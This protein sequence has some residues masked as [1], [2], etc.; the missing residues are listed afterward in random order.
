M[1]GFLGYLIG[2]AGGL[3]VGVIIGAALVS[4]F[5]WIQSGGV[6]IPYDQTHSAIANH[7]KVRD[8]TW[9]RNLAVKH[10][11]TGPVEF[12][13]YAPQSIYFPAHLQ[14]TQSI[15]V[16]TSGDDVDAVMCIVGPG[17]NSKAYVVLLSRMMA[18]EASITCFNQTATW[19]K[20]TDVGTVT[21][22]FDDVTTWLK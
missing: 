3:L 4:G 18:N 20:D 5:G 21:F 6:N 16:W 19:K 11:Q 17:N 10:L 22:V 8:V 2:G 13:P 9:G 14:T 12:S 1:N 15:W 7:V